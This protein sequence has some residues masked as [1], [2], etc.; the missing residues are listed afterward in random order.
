MKLI[1]QVSTDTLRKIADDVD[2]L[3]KA[4]INVTQLNVAGLLVTVSRRGDGRNG[5][6][7]YI[8]EIRSV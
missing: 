3:A 4:E 6:T 2:K 8:E 7:Y 5:W 1:G